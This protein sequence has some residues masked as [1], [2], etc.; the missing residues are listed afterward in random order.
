[1][2]TIILPRFIGTR[3]KAQE[4]VT[5]LGPELVTGGAVVI[6]ARSVKTATR[7]FT[8]E[9]VRLLAELGA[10]TINLIGASA[11]FASELETEAAAKHIRVSKGL[12]A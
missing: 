5:E 10:E 3:E 8:N 7:S 4:I 12:P 2:T 1:M 11:Q 6:A 9:L